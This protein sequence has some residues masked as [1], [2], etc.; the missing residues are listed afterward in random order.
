MSE[1]P[2]Q[3]DSRS[4]REYIQEMLDQ[5]AEL[6]AAS[7]DRRLATTLRMAAVEATRADDAA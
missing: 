3:P 2:H 7:G 1:G 5:L 6:A 4:V